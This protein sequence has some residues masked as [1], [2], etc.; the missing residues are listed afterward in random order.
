MPYQTLSG[1]CDYSDEDEDIRESG[2]LLMEKTSDFLGAPRKILECRDQ[3][4]PMC[5]KIGD[6]GKLY[7]TCYFPS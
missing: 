3:L 5:P 4:G 6:T 2:P 1:C 7:G